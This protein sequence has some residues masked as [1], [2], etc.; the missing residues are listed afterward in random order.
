MLIYGGSAFSYANDPDFTEVSSSQKF[1]QRVIDEYYEKYSGIRVWHEQLL[2]TAKTTG[3]IEIPS[4]RFYQF[5]PDLTKGYPRWPETTI[6]NYPVQG[7]GA[8]L[9]KL[10]RLEFDKRFTASGLEGEFISTIHDSLVADTPTKNVDAVARMLQEAIEAVPGLCKVVWDYD[11]S[12]PLTCEIQ[13]GM[14]KRD[15]KE[16]L[17]I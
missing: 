11:F 13:V 5:V 8:D 4:G 7:F 3:I 10:A 1:W 2:N 14:N 17:T 16:L 9:V 12:L 6:K 15:M